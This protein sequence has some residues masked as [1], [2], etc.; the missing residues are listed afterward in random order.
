MEKI[1]TLK[2]FYQN[3]FNWIPENLSKDWGHFNVFKLDP[4][5]GIGAKTVPYRRRDYYKIT[6]VKGSGTIYYANKIIEVK[7][8]AIVFSNPLVP[9]KWDSTENLRTGYFCIFNHDFFQQY[10]NFSAYSL[11]Q[12]SGTPV[13][14]LSDAGYESFQ[15]IFERMLAEIDSTYIHK[16]DM[17]R[18]LALEMMHTALK[19]EPANSSRYAPGNANQKISM[20]FLELLERQFPIEGPQ[21]KIKLKTPSDFANQLAVHVNH[22]N[23]AVKETTIKTTSQ[24]IAERISQ[25]AKLILSHG[26]WTI[27][28]I[29]EALGF[30]EISYFN[31]FFKKQ[32]GISPAK[33]RN[34]IHHGKTKIRE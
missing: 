13:I 17:L 29:A 8:N 25:E 6:L 9:Y 4:Y 20:L 11:Y 10:G 21:N 28:D 2:D 27:A 23:R 30:N 3:K 33:F 14:E 31:H 26:E 12:P 1:E 5:I 34:N 15:V 7:E 24:L 22:L 19:L 16:Y 18:N 32:V